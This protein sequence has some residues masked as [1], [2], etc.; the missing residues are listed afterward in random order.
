MMISTRHDTGDCPAPAH[1]SKGGRREH[2]RNKAKILEPLERIEMGHWFSWLQRG[3][4]SLRRKRADE[5]IRARRTKVSR[6]SASAQRSSDSKWGRGLQRDEVVRRNDEAPGRLT[7]LSLSC[8]QQEPGE[9]NRKQN[10]QP[11]NHKQETKHQNQGKH[12]H[13]GVVA[14]TRRIP[15]VEVREERRQKRH[16]NQ[17]ETTGFQQASYDPF[18]YAYSERMHRPESRLVGRVETRTQSSTG[19]VTSKRRS[20]EGQ[21]HL[22]APTRFTSPP[23]QFRVGN[24]ARA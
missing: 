5:P 15:L 20:T 18:V 19:R 17:H 9:R 10:D 14:E 7:L 16:Q 23:P 13:L 3:D 8:S 22:P 6:Q 4:K 1:L 21:R 2:E 11:A 24:P 12:H